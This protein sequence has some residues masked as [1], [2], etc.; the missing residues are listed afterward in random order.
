MRKRN[1]GVLVTYLLDLIP[2]YVFIMLNSYLF[3]FV[4]GVAICT[5]TVRCIREQTVFHF[6]DNEIFKCPM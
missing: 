3:G 5:L 2:F 4:L 6:V 1:G